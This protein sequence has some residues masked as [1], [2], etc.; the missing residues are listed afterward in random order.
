MIAIVL[1]TLEYILGAPYFWGAMGF[2]TAIGMFTGA[3]LYDGRIDQTG[4]GILSVL[5]YASMIIWMNLTRVSNILHGNLDIGHSQIGMAFAGTATV[6][7]VT[8]A[9]LVG[10]LL[11][12][13]IINIKYKEKQI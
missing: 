6:I 9:W 3:L 5:S 1:S 8:I 4:K 11:G 7:A 2:T 13:L 10:M 12:V